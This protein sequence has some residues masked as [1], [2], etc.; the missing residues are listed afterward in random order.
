[1]LF[2]IQHQT[3]ELWLKLMIHE[4]DAALV[5]LRADDVNGTLK[6]LARV[7]QVQRQLY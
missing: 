6:I 5:R 4:L 3:S 7:K 1:M 2:I